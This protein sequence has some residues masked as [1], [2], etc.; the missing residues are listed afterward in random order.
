MCSRAAGGV[1]GGVPSPSQYLEAM[2]SGE[3]GCA[4]V[5]V[6]AVRRCSRCGRSRAATARLLPLEVID[7][8]RRRPVAGAAAARA[9]RAP[10][11]GSIPSFAAFVGRASA[12]CGT[13]HAPVYNRIRVARGTLANLSVRSTACT[14]RV[15]EQAADPRPAGL[16]PRSSP[17][18]CFLPPLPLPPCLSIH[19]RA[20]CMA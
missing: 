18:R 9:C 5:A 7:V 16:Q 17:P 19:K 14:W 13:A 12:A 2:R 3:T 6:G 11:H 8:H 4:H 1:A 15:Q 20:C 10:A